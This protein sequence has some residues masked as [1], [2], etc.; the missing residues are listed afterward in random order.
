MFFADNLHFVDVTKKIIEKFFKKYLVNSKKCSTFAPGEMAEW[1]NAAVLKTVD[2]H[3]SGG[4]NPSLSAKSGKESIT[5]VVLFSFIA[6]LTEGWGLRGREYKIQKVPRFG[7]AVRIPP[8]GKGHRG[9]RKGKGSRCGAAASIARSIPNTI[10]GERSSQSHN[11]TQR[12]EQQSPIQYTEI[13][14]A[15]PTTMHRV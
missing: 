11:Y 7:C 3:G 14:V 10:H 2:L 5:K 6:I 15:N 9:K 8:F 4:S 13:A 1:S 12:V